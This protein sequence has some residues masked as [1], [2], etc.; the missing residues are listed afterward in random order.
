MP[1][2][3][4]EKN[5]AFET[6]LAIGSLRSPRLNKMKTT[7][8]CRKALTIFERKGIEE[9][10]SPHLIYKMA[11]NINLN[12]ISIHDEITERYRVDLE[13]RIKDPFI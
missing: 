11:Q 10:N 4:T 2:F 5:L 9:L 6:R 3:V 8:T 13:L 7:E 1:H 12:T